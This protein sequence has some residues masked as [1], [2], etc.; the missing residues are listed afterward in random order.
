[1]NTLD[2]SI[3]SDIRRPVIEGVIRRLNEH[4]APDQVMKNLYKLC[5]QILPYDLLYV[6]DGTYCSCELPNGITAGTAYDAFVIIDNECNVVDAIKLDTLA[7][8]LKTLKYNSSRSELLLANSHGTVLYRF[9]SIPCDAVNASNR[10]VIYKTPI[11]GVKSEIVRKQNGYNIYCTLRCI[12]D[13]SVT[14]IDGIKSL[15]QMEF[16]VEMVTNVGTCNKNFKL[17]NELNTAMT[18]LRKDPLGINS[19]DFDADDTSKH[20]LLIYQ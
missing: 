3:Q 18:Y 19:V 6:I 14:R 20:S 13:A 12:V 5:E 7:E 15:K 9:I 4:R 10:E 17:F 11:Y 16:L 8:Y 1:M 2:Y